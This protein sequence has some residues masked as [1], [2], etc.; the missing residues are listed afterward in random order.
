M[1]K[2]IPLVEIPGQSIDGVN[3]QAAPSGSGTVVTT[4]ATQTLSAKTLTSPTVTGGTF[5]GGTFTEPVIYQDTQA[6]VALGTNQATA[7]PITVTS[8]GFVFSTG[9]N[10][11]VG[12]LLDAAAANGST[13]HIK[14]G[15]ADILF[16]YPGVN[17]TINAIAA[18][19]KID[20]A[21][22]TS[23]TFIRL[24]TTSWQTIPTVPS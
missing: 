23:A 6:L 13:F 10:N 24:N 7:A 21:T 12:I 3:F 1:S 22:V 4:T 14:N 17:C 2:A 8:P 16:V 5:A 20:M 18:N 11:A 9:G 15:A 19:T